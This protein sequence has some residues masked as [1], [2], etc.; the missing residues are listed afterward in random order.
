[1]EDYLNA[2]GM[3]WFD[4]RADSV[5]RAGREDVKGIG[6]NA[7][8]GLSATSVSIPEGVM[9]IGDNAFSGCESLTDVQLRRV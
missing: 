8:V 7:F 5:C 3:P 4:V 9:S 2:T 1:M 6:D